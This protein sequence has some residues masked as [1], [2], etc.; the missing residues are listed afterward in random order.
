MAGRV[1]DVTGEPSRTRSEL[2]AVVPVATKK[3]VVSGELNLESQEFG[4]ELQHP[5]D[6]AEW[7]N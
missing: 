2:R 5:T 1:N 7:Y 3:K 6:V 4:S